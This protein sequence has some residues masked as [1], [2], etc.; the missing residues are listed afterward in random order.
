MKDSMLVLEIESDYVSGLVVTNYS[1]C[2][3][4]LNQYDIFSINCCKLSKTKFNRNF[5]LEPIV[6]ITNERG[7]IL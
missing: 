4:L 6:S 1:A 3:S 7:D 2:R 5:W